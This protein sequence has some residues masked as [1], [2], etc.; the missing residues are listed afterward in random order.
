MSKQTISSWILASAEE[1]KA[2]QE[3]AK[4][5]LDCPIPPNEILANLSLFM[6]RSA[7][8]QLLFMHDLYRRILTV[9]GV[10]VEFGTRYGRNLGLFTTLRTIYEPHNFS[11]KIIGFDTFTGFPSMAPQDG[12][13]EGVTI[14][15]LSVTPEYESYLE[16]LLSTHEKLAPRSQLKKYELVK[17][18]VSETLPQY[19]ADHPEI[20]IALAYFD[21]DLYQPTKNCLALIKDHLTKGSVLGFDELALAEFPG[22]T[23]ALKEEFGIGNYE[24]KRDPTSGYQSFIVIQ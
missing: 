10:V 18:D 3:L 12:T 1:V 6:T 5:L 13:Y 21:L 9:P 15:S 11:R 14:G 24:I 22:E 17:G 20:I 7:L 8:A 23:L 2:Y 16:H 4:M 19:L